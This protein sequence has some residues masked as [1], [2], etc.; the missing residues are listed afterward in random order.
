MATIRA[1]ASYQ[2]SRS[3]EDLA[4]SIKPDELLQKRRIGKSAT[5]CLFVVDASGSM[6]TQQRM[7][8][9]KG[10][11]FSLLEESYK[12]RDRVGLIAFRGEGAD[13]VL[14][15]SSSID[16]AYNRLSQLPTGGKTPLAAGLQ[17]ALT[18]LMN[19]KRKYPTLTPLLV[20]ITDGRANVGNGGKLKEELASLAGDPG[21]S[22][23]SNP[24][25]RYRSFEER[26]IWDSTW[27]LPVYCGADPWKV[28]QDG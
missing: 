13:L 12:K 16:L 28:F 23:D 14:P 6:G 19:E 25:Y 24:D 1:V 11:V 5:A 2:K 17:K 4:V 20:L 27:V 7:E 22:R 8:A 21:K 18:T 26:R 10:A 15:L 3:S 9:A